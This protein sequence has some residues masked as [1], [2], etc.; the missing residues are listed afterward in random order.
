[1]K[2][3]VSDVRPAPRAHGMC[4]SELPA[5]WLKSETIIISARGQSD[6]RLMWC[7]I[8]TIMAWAFRAHDEGLFAASI[9]PREQNGELATR[10]RHSTQRSVMLMSSK[11]AA[12]GTDRRAEERDFVGKKLRLEKYNMRSWIFSYCW[13]YRNKSM[14]VILYSIFG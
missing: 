3:R 5:H 2:W 13:R 7:F 10:K 12:L 6:Y 4:M 11:L 9:G 8:K 14:S 1:M